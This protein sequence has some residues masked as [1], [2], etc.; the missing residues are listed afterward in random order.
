MAN[1]TYNN[2]I[3]TEFV[4]QLGTA[5]RTGYF[6][7]AGYKIP[8][9]APHTAT[10]RLSYDL[11]FGDLRGLGAFVEYTYQS[12]YFIDNG[13]VLTIPGYGLV[14]ANVHFDR[15]VDLL[16]LKRFSAYFEV[17]NIFD[18]NW[19]ASANNIQN[20]VGLVNGQIVQAGYTTLAQNATGSIYAGN[21][22]LFQGGVRFKF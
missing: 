13:N 1:Y 4:E 2:Q 10:G 18:R 5:A 11:P 15:D 12:S 20:Q 3:F 9:V 16:W 17:R 8:G 7:R 22:R 19:V 14:S 21:P 6:D